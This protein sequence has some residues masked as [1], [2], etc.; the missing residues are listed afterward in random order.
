MGSDTAATRTQVVRHRSP[1]ASGSTKD[2]ILDSAEAL[3]ADAD[4]ASVTM[5]AVAE[6]AEVDPASITYHFGGKTQLMAA[7][8]RRRYAI[9]SEHRMRELTRVLAESEEI[10][11]ARE[12]LDT[13]HRPWFELI[14]TGDV[15]WRSFAK[16][17]AAMPDSPVLRE[18]IS[19]QSG[20]WEMALN[21]AL[22]RALPDADEA[23]I[24]QAFTLT[25]GAAIYVAV[26]PPR[27]LV[28]E[29]PGEPVGGALSYPDFLEFIAAGFEGMVSGP[30]A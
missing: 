9:L 15:G 8:I 5:R 10:P 17:V 14:S 7:V 16:I 29:Q 4:L 26:P 21:A 12:L 30:S 20:D 6:H 13:V 18:L 22:R 19:E 24:Q 3:F 25:V 11:T 2:A 27:A 23:V 1:T 28:D